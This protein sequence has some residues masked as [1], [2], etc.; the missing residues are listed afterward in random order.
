MLLE[1]LPKPMNIEV[2]T[3]LTLKMWRGFFIKFTYQIIYSKIVFYLKPI[4]AVLR[5]SSK[6]VFL[7]ILQYSQK[8][9]CWSLLQLYQKETPT[10]VLF[11]KYCNIFKNSFFYE[12][13]L[14]AVS[15]KTTVTIF[16]L[17][18]HFESWLHITTTKGPYGPS[19]HQMITTFLHVPPPRKLNLVGNLILPCMLL[20]N[21]QT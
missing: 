17:L 21:S 15:E 2:R 18:N 13:P 10:Q 5:C 9:K 8:N 16:Q 7:K 4:A 14:A 1:V 11:C 20:K 19:W 6:W 3:F 12:T